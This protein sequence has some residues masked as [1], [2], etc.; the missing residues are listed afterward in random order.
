[1]TIRAVQN[2]RESLDYFPEAD[3][4]GLLSEEWHT[5]ARKNGYVRRDRAEIDSRLWISEHGKGPICPEMRRVLTRHQKLLRKFARDG[6]MHDAMLGGV[7]AL[8]AEVS[9]GHHGGYAALAEFK[10]SFYKQADWTGRRTP[11]DVQQEWYRACVGGIEQVAIERV[12]L[13]DPCIIEEAERGKDPNRF[14]DPK[15]GLRARHLRQAVEKTGKLAVGPGMSIY[16]HADGVWV[17]D[18]RTEIKRRTIRL[19]G[20]RYRQNHAALIT[21]MIE[22]REPLISDDSQDTKFFNL[23]NGLL[24]WQTGTLY[25]HNPAATSTIRIPIEWNED[26]ECPA[27]DT[28]LK[29]VLP[30]DAIELAYEVLGYMLYNDNPLH[31]AILLHGSGRNGKGTFIRLARRLVGGNN[32]SAIAPQDLDSSSFLGAQLHGKLANLVGDV[33]PKIFKQTEKFKQMCGDDYITAQ[34]KYGQPFNFKSRAL[35]IAAFNALPRSADTTEGFFSRWIVI[36]FTGYFPAGKADTGLLHRLTTPEELQGLLRAAV[37]GLQSLMLRGAFREPESVKEATK[38][39]RIEADPIRAFLSER[40]E[41]HEPAEKA[42][43]ARTEIYTDYVSWAG[44]NG[45]Q[46]F[47]ARKFYSLFMSA[48]PDILGRSLMVKMKDGYPYI[49]D[50]ALRK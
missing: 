37:F 26:A 25:P 32:I 38:E 13:G 39:F 3:E 21:D 14:F 40:I 18:G 9:A 49:L 42:R 19:M 16:R 27:V 10:T 33:D 22:A 15:H 24:D 29:Q 1:M 47:S 28:W 2:I 6:G 46:P 36:P 7:W 50:I 35:M 8:L 5:L 4:L 43:M 45:Y 20:Q 12:R 41:L 30:M 17:P 11:D 23:P 34:H 44:M 48:A 31:K